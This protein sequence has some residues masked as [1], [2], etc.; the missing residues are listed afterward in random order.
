MSNRT[1]VMMAAIVGLCLGLGIYVVGPAVA[2]RLSHR[3]RCK[4]GKDATK[5]DVLAVAKACAAD[6]DIGTS[7]IGGDNAVLGVWKAGD[8]R[9]RRVVVRAGV[10]RTEGFEVK[11][12]RKNGAGSEYEVTKPE[13]YAVYA[14]KTNI[15]K[16][17]KG[18]DRSV[19][20][21][22]APYGPHLD[23]PAIVE[24][25]RLYLDD[26]ADDAGV[27]L[28]KRDVRS[29]ADPEALVTETVSGRVLVTLFVIEHIDP[30][31][32]AARGAKKTAERVLALIGANGEHA[33]DYAFSEAEAGGLP[34]FRSATY[35]ETRDRYPSAKLKEGFYD[36]VRDHENGAMATYCYLDWALSRLS[37]D[38]FVRLKDEGDLGAWLA[39]AYNHG[40]YG[41]SKIVEEHPDDWEDPGNGFGD[42]TLGYV[43]EFREVYGLLWKGK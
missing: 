8:V 28:D 24:R 10:S 35:E 11:L 20:V 16:R 43:Q 4:V 42:G 40:L 27:A 22:Y 34:Q 21:T 7:R 5:A 23:D 38:D 33:Y 26:L 31:D 39:A 6:G 18:G 12:L 19:A 13:G 32:F 1:I 14:L 15:K 9:I 29:R 25:G 17:P 30:D 36:G 2:G 41:A 3:D 37:P